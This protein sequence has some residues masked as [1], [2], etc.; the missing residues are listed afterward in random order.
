MSLATSGRR[1]AP[2]LLSLLWASVIP[3]HAQAPEV[4]VALGGVAPLGTMSDRYDVGLNG[5][6][7]LG[8]GLRDGG[9]G[10][11]AELW[12]TRFAGK[13]E[14]TPYARVH[15]GGLWDVGLLGNAVFAAKQ[16]HLRPYALLG[17]GLHRQLRDDGHD[18]YGWVPGAQAGVGLSW[19]VGQLVLSAEIQYQVVLSEVAAGCD[20]CVA[21]QTPLVIGVG[22]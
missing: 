14:A 11:R 16:E 17:G 20:F 22:L 18:P 3:L 6:L 19:S 9:F 12:G 4:R 13:T 8:Y 7:S 10:V 21:S 2:V 5:A 1:S 15:Q